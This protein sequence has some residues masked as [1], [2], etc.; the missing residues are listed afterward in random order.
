MKIE[1]VKHVIAI[2]KAK[3][4]TKAAQNLFTTQSNLSYSLKQLEN[5]FGRKILIRSNN[6][7]TLTPFGEEF[8]VKA[9]EVVK[10]FDEL[11]MLGKSCSSLDLSISS[12][13]LSFVSKTFTE[14]ANYYSEAALHLSLKRGISD[15]LYSVVTQ[16][17]DVGYIYYSKKSEDKIL[18]E[19][20]DN[21]LEFHS[22]FVTD[23]YVYVRK[24]HSL[25][26]DIVGYADIHELDNLSRVHV[27]DCNDDLF[28][29]TEPLI[30]KNSKD[31]FYVEGVYSLIDVISRTDYYFIGLQPIYRNSLTNENMIRFPL[32]GTDDKIIFGYVTKNNYSLNE[33]GKQFINLLKQNLDL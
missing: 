19:I 14:L 29:Y 13:P 4:I 26:T 8:I 15:V 9:N 6:G 28:K 33:T 3:S 31:S 17:S 24:N 22:L 10:S 7:T 23:L 32:S 16:E 30:S 25:F 20:S 21:N 5:E 12:F 18:S 1:Q 27:L 2:V 11:A